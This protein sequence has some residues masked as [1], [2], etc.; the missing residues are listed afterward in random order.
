M[1]GKIA[2]NKM[3]DKNTRVDFLIANPYKILF[4]EIKK[5]TVIHRRFFYW[6]RKNITRNYTTAAY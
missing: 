3:A 1:A 6:V 5:P 4:L 2:Q